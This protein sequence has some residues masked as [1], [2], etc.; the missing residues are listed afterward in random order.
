[1]EN[2]NPATCLSCGNSGDIIS[3]LPCLK[4]FYAKTGRKT[5]YYLQLG[6]QGFYYEGAEHPVKENNTQVML[7]SY[8]ADGLRPLLLNQPYIEDVR[9][10][11]GEKIDINFNKIRETEVN[12]PYGELRH[13][14]R[15][16]FP[17]LACDLSKPYIHAGI[18]TKDFATGKI[19]VNRTQRY[20]N[21]NIN[22]S[23]LKDYDCL[24]AG[25]E[26]EHE[27]FCK[28]FGLDMPL[29][30]VDNFLELAQAIEQSVCLVGNQSFCFSIA[31]A[32]KH[33]RVLEVCHFVPNVLPIGENAFD[34][35]SQTGLEYYVKT[36]S[37]QAA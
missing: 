31:E 15:F 33:P 21:P 4:E 37:K 24:F 22:Y 14:Y 29:L 32:V 11:T 27:I 28:E 10:W 2:I 5:I 19:L 36:L 26:I 13:W 9:V 17:D 1:M 34:F 20:H 6:V 30:K 16:I 3:S 18:P 35:L 8:M 7:N 25:M 12:Q 23:F